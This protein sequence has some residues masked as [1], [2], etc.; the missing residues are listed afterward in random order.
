MAKMNT[1]IKNKR[2]K[3]DI[4]LTWKA[5]ES[6]NTYEVILSTPMQGDICN[7]MHEEI[8]NAKMEWINEEKDYFNERNKSAKKAALQCGHIFYVTALAYHFVKNQM[9]CPICRAGEK[10]KMN[11]QGIPKRIRGD[12]MQ[13]AKKMIQEE[14]IQQNEEETREN[15]REIERIVSQDV[16]VN[17]FL[18]VNRR[19]TVIDFEVTFLNETGYLVNSVIFLT[20]KEDRNIS[21]DMEYI[22][23]R[24]Q[25]RKFQRF[26][27]ELPRYPAAMTIAVLQNNNPIAETK[28][29]QMATVTSPDQ[30]QMTNHREGNDFHLMQTETKEIVNGIATE[31]VRGWI[32]IETINLT[33][34]QE[35]SPCPIVNLKWTSL[36]L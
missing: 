23:P 29:I 6:Q 22:V 26:V 32:W 33:E 8:A 35:T 15:Q 14:Q 21:G 4:V 12:I 25:I 11:A 17:F 2:V 1:R 31:N 3:E 24:S 28:V 20:T 36:I 34:F 13:R 27:D 5:R 9:I 18:S 19:T 7:I 16:L 30:T 10:N